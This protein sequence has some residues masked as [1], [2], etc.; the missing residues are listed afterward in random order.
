MRTGVIAPIERVERDNKIIQEE[1]AYRFEIGNGFFRGDGSLDVHRPG[2]GTESPKC[3][4]LCA[5]GLVV[6]SPP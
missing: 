5:A 2:I 6:D 1:S 4:G 3:G